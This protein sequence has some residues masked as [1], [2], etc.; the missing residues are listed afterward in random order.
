MRVLVF[1][2]ETIPDLVMAHR[3]WGIDAEAPDAYQKAFEMRLEETERKSEFM[4]PA[5]HRVVAVGMVGMDLDKRS[6]SV[7]RSSGPNEAEHLRQ[8]HLM[9]AGNPVLVTWNGLAFD[10]AVLRYRA[11]YHGLPL[12]LLYCAALR[13]Y[14]R[15]DYRFGEKHFDLM[16]VLSGFGRSAGLKL[17]EM[18]ALCDIPCKQEGSGALVLERFLAGDHEAN[19]NYVEEDAR[20][21]ARIFLRW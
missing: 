21:T 12:P 14:D 18:A 9:L 2:T 11:L 1:D 15:Y 10:L 17:S 13:N 6:V 8:F 19:A 16:D 7:V 3:V 4:K 20:A 5:F